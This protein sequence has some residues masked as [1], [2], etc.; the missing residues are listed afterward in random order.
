MNPMTNKK[1]L[2]RAVCGRRLRSGG[3]VNLPR[4]AI[5]VKIEVPVIFS[6]GSV[7]FELAYLS[8]TEF[9]EIFGLIH[10]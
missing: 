7:K 5:E 9:G 10:I 3:I 1:S 6:D 4:P 8:D 2:Y